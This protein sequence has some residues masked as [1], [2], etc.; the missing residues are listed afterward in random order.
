MSK[1]SL[2][3]LIG[4]L[5]ENSSA[6]CQIEEAVN[7]ILLRNKFYTA[8][9]SDTEKYVVIAKMAIGKPL[10]GLLSIDK[11]LVEDIK[12]WFDD[13]RDKGPYDIDELIRLKGRISKITPPTAESTEISSLLDNLFYAIIN[14]I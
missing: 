12:A 13:T 10:P 5:P 7:G 9:Y 2:K 1:E 4:A 6:L 3:T 8:D 14:N 11:Q